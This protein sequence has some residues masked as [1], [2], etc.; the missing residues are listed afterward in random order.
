MSSA[1][2]I[3]D[4][5][6]PNNKDDDKAY[7]ASDAKEVQVADYYAMSFLAERGALTTPKRD[8]PCARCT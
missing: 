3:F 7:S 8:Q 4:M 2:T 6:R 1:P 5:R